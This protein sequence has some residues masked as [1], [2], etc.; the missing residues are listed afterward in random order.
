M[1]R[2]VYVSS[3]ISRILSALTSLSDRR[4]YLSAS[5]LAQRLH[6]RLRPRNLL[7]VAHLDLRPE[8]LPQ[9]FPPARVHLQRRSAR[10]RLDTARQLLPRVLL[11][12]VLG[13]EGL[14]ERPVRLHGHGRGEDCV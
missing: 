12:G 5:S 11:P 3:A 9:D 2:P 10:L 7:L 1:S 14:D 8:L 13:D 4:V 6:V